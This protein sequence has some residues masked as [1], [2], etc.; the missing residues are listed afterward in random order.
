MTE[1]LKQTIKEEM[2]QMPQEIQEAIN[3]F[4]WVKVTEEI[5]K[6]FDL[7]ENQ[8]NDFQAETSL[9][10]MGLAALD[11]YAT[12]IENHV[13][14]TKADAE[15]IAS[16]AYQKIFAPIENILA[17]KAKNL[18]KNKTPNFAQNID[19]ILSGGNYTIFLENYRSPVENS[20]TERD[21]LMG[22]T[23]KIEGMKSKLLSDNREY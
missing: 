2:L 12:N 18:I 8:I 17:E 16:E 9:A 4:D 10:I 1:K 3:S 19:F 6:E 21:S 15:K 5:G 13:E 20:D 11:F 7:D 14:T 23:S 22:N